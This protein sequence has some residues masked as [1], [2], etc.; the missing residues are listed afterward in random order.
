MLVGVAVIVCMIMC[1]IVSVAVIVCMI[2]CMIVGVAAACIMDVIVAVIVAAVGSVNM[3]FRRVFLGQQCGRCCL[4]E[5][6]G[7]G[8]KLIHAG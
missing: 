1:V 8:R 7:L 4:H 3:T 5:V 6:I 2:V